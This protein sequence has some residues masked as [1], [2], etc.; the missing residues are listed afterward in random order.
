M[1]K[2]LYVKEIDKLRA[3]NA[4]HRPHSTIFRRDNRFT[5]RLSD[6]FDS[7]APVEPGHFAYI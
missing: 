3:K 1:A 6:P 4:V 5:C 7:H 2:S